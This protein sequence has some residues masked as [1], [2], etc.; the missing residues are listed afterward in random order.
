MSLTCD[1]ISYT[2]NLAREREDARHAFPWNGEATVLRGRMA[3]LSSLR[4][5]SARI[6][7]RTSARTGD[8]VFLLVVLVT[9]V[10]IFTSAAHLF[11]LPQTI[12][13]LALGVVYSLVGTLGFERARLARSGFVTLIYFAFQIAL[14][15]LIVILGQAPG[16]GRVLLLPL[17]AQAV[18]VLAR[19]WLAVLCVAL[20]IAVIAPEGVRSGW[21]SILPSAVTYL[22][23]VIFVVGFAYLTLREERARDEIERLAAELRSAN[24]KLREYVLQAEELATTRERNRLAREIHDGLG[25]YL[26][27]ISMQLQA[28]RAVWD[29]DPARAADAL[30]KAQTLTREA[31]T[32][33]RRSVAALRAS[34]TTDRTLAQALSTLVEESRAAGLQ[35][36]LTTR[37]T[38]RTLSPQTELALYRT[39]QEGLTNIRKHAHATRADLVLDFT[40]P[41]CVGLTVHDDG[42]GAAN[43]NG[44]FGLVGLRERVQFLGGEVCIKTEAGQ[45]F[46]LEV[47]VP[48]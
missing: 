47:Q 9:F 10:A 2:L 4:Q 16:P 33:V 8:V 34:P 28:A 3:F 22:A 41:D 24:D 29:S 13:L 6:S 48:G 7:A 37:G 23:G 35:T 45:G 31:L 46:T 38:K 27:A 20:V 14:A 42:A 17:A 15:V 40:A 11:T 30:G 26:T 19:R 32:D 36:E 43:T 39:V 5:F 18:F 44:G 25:H 21:Q 12:A 1:L